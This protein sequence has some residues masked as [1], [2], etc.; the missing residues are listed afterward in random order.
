M[1]IERLKNRVEKL[2]AVPAVKSVTPGPTIVIVEG[3]PVPLNPGGVTIIVK[4]EET[5]DAIAGGV[6]GRVLTDVGGGDDGSE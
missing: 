4:T 6:A 2:E 3:Q 1:E 5:R